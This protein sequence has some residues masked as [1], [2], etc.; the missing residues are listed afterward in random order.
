MGLLD[1]IDQ[2]VART[3]LRVGSSMGM[4]Q[5][6]LLA[7]LAGGLVESGLRN[8][9]Y[10]DRDSLGVFQQRP[11]MGWGSPSQ[12]RNPEYAAKKFFSELK[13]VWNDGR[14]IGQNVQAVQRS[15][16]PD[17]YD[18]RLG[19]ARQILRALGNDLGEGATPLPEGM[20]PVLGAGELPDEMDPYFDDGDGPDIENQWRNA[21]AAMAQS[22]RSQYDPNGDLFD[23]GGDD[24]FNPLAP[25]EYA[26]DQLQQIAM[27]RAGIGDI[28]DRATGS[29]DQ[30]TMLQETGTR[31][32][33]AQAQ[34]RMQAV[35]MAAAAAQGRM[36][37]FERI[38]G[39]G[40]GSLPGRGGKIGKPSGASV[41][42]GLSQWTSAGAR[43]ARQLGFS[44][45]IGG[46]GGR[47][48]KSD[49]PT[50]H[51]IDLMTGLSAAGKRNGWALA[52]YY[53]SNRGKLRVKYI[54]FDGRIASSVDNW[55][56]RHYGSTPDGNTSATALHKD[57]VHI[58]FY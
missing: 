42:S 1:Q 14:S 18:Q 46:I 27:A 53:H 25:G 51:A 44:G 10:G 26:E 22:I 33:A 11:S 54:I 13:K 4:N 36:A 5:Q 38:S 23:D 34:E 24:D 55:R 49:H 30:V 19:D 58:S 37:E 48:Y 32:A 28:G 17:R 40:K 56:W 2:G 16:F 21:L 20:I 47:G 57:H 8:V 7:G 29:A 50:G 6:Q 9:N 3:I 39:L 52:N 12:V 31:Y 45:T 15:A 43:V 35:Q 41:P